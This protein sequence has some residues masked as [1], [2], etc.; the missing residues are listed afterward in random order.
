MESDYVRKIIG[1]IL[2]LIIFLLTSCGSYEDDNMKVYGLKEAYDAGF[3]NKDDVMHIG[4]FMSGE[5]FEV[6]NTI[7][8][9]VKID[10]IPQ[11][12]MPELS[13]INDNTIDKI[14]IAFYEK[15]KQA[16]DAELNR[17]KSDGYLAE[18]ISAIETISILLF[19]GEYKG[20]FAVQI[21]TS[22]INYG[23]GS[24]EVVVD[25]VAWTQFA[26]EIVIY[27]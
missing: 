16:M 5:I 11:I 9:W 3:L 2:I 25:N 26:P 13:D 24:F 12:V 8:E 6:Q 18:D 20:A 10:F 17:L 27:K 19:L 23:E 15:N 1:F 7:D 14:K 4:F 21:T 22:L